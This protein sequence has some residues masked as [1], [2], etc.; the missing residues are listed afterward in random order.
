MATIVI[1]RVKAPSGKSYEV[2]W[3]P[4]DKTL[5]VGHERVGKA[6]TPTEAMIKAEAFAFKR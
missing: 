4:H 2:K 6:A 1:G 3:D 5:Y